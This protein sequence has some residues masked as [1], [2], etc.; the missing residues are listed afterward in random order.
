[1]V[2]SRVGAKKMANRI[3]CVAKSLIVQRF[4]V[5][6]NLLTQVAISVA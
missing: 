1:M 3:S 4:L 5:K 2:A 6:I